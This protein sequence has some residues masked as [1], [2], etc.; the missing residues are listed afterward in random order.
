MGETKVISIIN[1]KGGVG[2]TTTT[3][4]LAYALSKMGKKV[5]AVDFDQQASLTNYLNYGLDGEYYYSIY[6]LLVKVFRDISP[7]EDEYLSKTN[8]KDLINEIIVKPTY[9]T[10]ELT[11]DEEGK[12]KV[13]N[14]QKEFGFDLL[15]A[16]IE[17]ADF[18]LELSQS[19]QFNKK[20]YYLDALIGEITDCREYDY[21]LIDCNPSLG[22]LTMNAIIAG[23]DGIIIPTNLDLMS[24]RG[25]MSLLGKIADTQKALYSATKGTVFHKGVIGI[26]MNLYSD[27]RVV[28]RTLATDIDSFYP[29]YVFKSAIP[30]SAM[31]KRAV[32]E[33]VIY[34]MKYQK[35]DKAYEL[36][37]SELLRRLKKM[38]A[39]KKHLTY[40]F[41]TEERKVVTED[42]DTGERVIIE[43]AMTSKAKEE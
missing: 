23:L 5:L 31:A 34:S 38:D 40:S 41:D 35:A 6:E 18:E 21:I 15:P 28:D 22:I 7:S 2:K 20:A 10:R 26:V 33:G 14:I 9:L 25:I 4:N 37:A 42:L 39:E 27:K 11:E 8:L 36:L 29:L 24:T 1:Q 17:L 3:A 32:L 19:A 13:M 12:K 43:N 30:D 16:S